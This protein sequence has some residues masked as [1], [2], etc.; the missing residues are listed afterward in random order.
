MQII[1]RVL[2][3]A[4]LALPLAACQ[5]DDAPEQVER[6]PLTAP[7]NGDSAQWRAYLQDL[8][9]RHMEGIQNQPYIYLVPDDA[10]ADFDAQF[11]RLSEKAQTDVARGI[12]RGN[13]LAYA[14]ADSNRVADMVVAA[15][16][17]V[18]KG[19]MDGVRVLFIGDAADSQRVE[20]AVAP[21]G[22][23]YVFVEK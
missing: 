19:S 6:A 2:L 8:V 21:A 9:P 12:I 20:Q 22:V 15:F 10:V 1:T 3:A 23:E 18:P 11:E 7:A 5:K 13:L 16:E 14:G 17:N 4:S